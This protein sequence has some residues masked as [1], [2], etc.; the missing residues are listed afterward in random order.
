MSNHSNPAHFGAVAILL[1]W[2]MAIALISVWLIGL[3]MTDLPGISP[4]KLKLF[5]WHKWLGVCILTLTLIR[6]LW[7]VTHPAPKLPSNMPAW[8]RISAIATHHSLYL[9][10]FAIPLTGYF[11]SLSAGYPIVLFGIL[12]LPVLI[13]K[14]TDLAPILAEVHEILAYV[15]AALVLLHAMAA[16]KHHWLD[17][18]DVLSQMLP[19]LRKKP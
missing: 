6:L 11:F 18:D 9:L 8:E 7:R 5:N 12:P 16:I 15:L 4:L 17:K 10:M 13:E 3:Y 2:L 19:F 14:N 1:H